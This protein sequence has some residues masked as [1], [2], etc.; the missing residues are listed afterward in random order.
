MKVEIQRLILSL[1][2]PLLLLLMLYAIKILEVGMG[3][4]L[5]HFGIYPLHVKGVIGIITSPL[6]HSSFSHLIANSFPL[7][8][9]TWCLF[10]FYHSIAI[11]I[12]TALWIS[13]GCFTFIIGSP[14]W[15]IG[16]SG[17]IYGLVFFLFLSGVIRKYPP[18]IAISLLITFLYGGIVWSMFPFFVKANISW[19]GHLSGGITGMIL[20]LLFKSYGPQKRI[21]TDDEESNTDIETEEESDRNEQDAT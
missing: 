19:E 12:L 14:G 10:Y 13:S 15:H 4:D 8:F 21:I 20:A 3:W 17:V 1:V 7:L 11:Q 18:L 6:V 9:L 2:I 5:S 16:A